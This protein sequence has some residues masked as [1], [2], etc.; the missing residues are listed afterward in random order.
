MVTVDDVRSLALAL[1]RTEEHLIRDR[2]K[3]RIGR[4]VYLALSR[5]ETELGFAFPKEERAALVASEPEKFSLPGAGD[6]RYHWVHARMAALDAGELEELVT[7]A[8]RMCV[9]AKVARAHLGDPDGG[10]PPAPG[11]DRLRAAAEVFAAF[12]GVDRSWL[13]L[14]ADTAP[15]LDLSG[16]GHRTA[17][18]RWLN[19]WGCRIRYP[20]EGEPDPLGTG[21]GAWWDRH[22]LPGTPLA[23][24]TDRDIARLAAA[25]G[26]LAALPLGRRTLGPTAAAKALFA[27]RPRTVMPWDAAIAARLHGGRDAQAFDRH[28][29]T[30]RAWAR[31]ALAESGLDEDALTAELGRPGLPLA[32]VLDE[33][34]YVTLSHSSGTPTPAPAQAPAPR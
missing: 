23:A 8:W 2:V 25:Y 1:P 29:R 9:P 10:L 15:G 7:D 4:I 19:A 34:L 33:Y 22:T 3:F 26:D 11:L 12:P 13:A 27:L 14:V 5:D 17:L 18:H 6:M 32:K 24:L 28:L 21:L 20:R 16:A 30:G 31:A